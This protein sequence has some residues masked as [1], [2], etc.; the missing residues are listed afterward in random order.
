MAQEND[1][2]DNYMEII[3]DIDNNVTLPIEIIIHIMSYLT[4]SDRISAGLVCR[5]WYDASL[6]FKFINKQL[7]IVNRERDN[8]QHVM[9]TLVKSQR[10]YYHFL[11]KDVEVKR[12][13]PIWDKFGAMMRSL[14]LICCDLSERTLVNILKSC[15]NLR[16]L[17]INA[18][19]ECLMSG[20]LLDDEN[21]VK[22]LSNNFQSLIELSLASN[23]YLSDALFNRLVSICPNLESLSLADCQISFHSGVYK[24]F[25]PDYKSHEQASESL[26]TF[27]NVLMYI[28]KQAMKLKHLSF[29]STLIDSTALSRLAEVKGLKL[30]SLKL[31]SCDQLTNTALRYLSCQISLR[32]LD[33]SFCTRVTDA[34]LLCICQNLQNI[35][36][37]NIRRCRAITDYGISQISLLQNLKELDIS[38]CDQLTGACIT[39]GL[40][41]ASTRKDNTTS[42]QS[43]NKCHDT[44]NV[45]P[46]FSTSPTKSDNIEILRNYSL[47]SLSA[48][49]LNLDE[50]SIESIADSFCNLKYLDIG[51]CFSAVTDKTIQKLFK[52][53]ILLRTLKISRCDKVSDAGLTGMGAKN[54]VNLVVDSPMD[55]NPELTESKLRIRLG[56]KAEME[57]VRDANRK[58]EVME[59]CEDPISPLDFDNIPGFSL[60]R[61]Q[62]LRVLDLMGCNRVTDVSLKHAF[63]F[64]ELKILDLSMCQQITHVGLDYLTRNNTAIEDLNLSQCHNVTDVGIFYVAHRLH[65]L[66]RLHIRGCSQLTDHSFYSIK[67]YAKNLHY[68]D[69]CSCRGISHAGVES[70]SHLHV[71]YSDHMDPMSSDDLPIPPTFIRR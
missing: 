59:M 56:S 61:L 31:K 22:E 44:E 4:V 23:R 32:V 14:I 34:S 54:R 45:N 33:I 46:N 17:H 55:K 19:R 36:I 47:E 12:N 39:Q 41:H 11:F 68:L 28:Q 49:A 13:L 70:L 53:L 30:E 24:R 38:E 57:I 66:E 40:C 18:C 26:L 2:D 21:D 29:G 8:M 71:K 58:R 42:S 69:A 67:L 6:S 15:K 65:R 1:I 3:N 25:Y 43:I 9:N 52:E 35:E 37:L 60:I 16:I 50:K 64:P 27:F 20:R 7:M 51:Y 62:G 63:T 5:Q 48:N 10:L